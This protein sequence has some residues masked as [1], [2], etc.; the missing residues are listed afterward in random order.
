MQTH[1]FLPER[2]FVEENNNNNATI[3]ANLYQKLFTETV[4]DWY[5]IKIYQLDDIQIVTNT[6]ITV[7][8][9]LQVEFEVQ[10]WR[11]LHR[12]YVR[13]MLLQNKNKK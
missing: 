9:N 10:P 12:N 5:L 11:R 1:M 13:Y 6:Y 8:I 2:S 3:K 7:V 4:V